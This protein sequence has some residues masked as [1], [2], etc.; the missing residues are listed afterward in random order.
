MNDKKILKHIDNTDGFFTLADILKN[1]D[2]DN[3][4]LNED[5]LNVI[6]LF[7]YL[8]NDGIVYRISHEKVDY[9]ITPENFLKLIRDQNITKLLGLGPDE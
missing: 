1:N 4:N 5:Y 2:S 9:Y 3:Q 7:F 8:E 6:Q